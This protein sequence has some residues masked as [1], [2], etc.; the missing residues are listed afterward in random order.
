M[1]YAEKHLSTS[2]NSI[3]SSLVVIKE[4]DTKK[5]KIR[6]VR[7]LLIYAWE[8]IQ[9]EK[10]I[11]VI[12][13]NFQPLFWGRLKNVLRQ[14]KK[15][16]LLNFLFENSNLINQSFD[17]EQFITKIEKLERELFLVKEKLERLNKVSSEASEDNVILQ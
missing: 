5:R 14:N 3:L 6:S 16:C 9:D 13:T 7:G 17:Q 11:T 15:N 10:L 4:L 12:K 8:I 2:F 1:V